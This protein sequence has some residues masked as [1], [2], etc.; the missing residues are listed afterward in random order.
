MGGMRPLRRLPLV[1]EG[2][3]HFWEG[4]AA[5]GGARRDGGDHLGRHRAL[6][7]FLHARL[8]G[9]DL[10]TLVPS[11]QLALAQQ[12]VSAYWSTP[13]GLSLLGA[14]ER[15]F[16]IPFHIACS[17]HRAAG[18]S[19]QADPLAVAGDLLPRLVDALI[20]GFAWPMLKP[21]PGARMRWKGLLGLTVLAGL[22]DHASGCAH[23]EPAPEVLELPP[24]PEPLSAADLGEVPETSENL[25]NSRYNN[26]R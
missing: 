11:E 23:P 12:Q 19:A 2:C 13:L 1:G 5:G 7:L 9:R 21:M 10:A 8:R 14:V 24:L 6:H 15:A 20:P 3:P 26:G 18:L 25:E 4:Y 22:C 16:T 17:R